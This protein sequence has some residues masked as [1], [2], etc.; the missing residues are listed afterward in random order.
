MDNIGRKSQREEEE[1]NKYLKG[2]MQSSLRI[3]ILIFSFP[4]TFKFSLSIFY[5]KG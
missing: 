3:I 1:A 5:P 2:L 4:G